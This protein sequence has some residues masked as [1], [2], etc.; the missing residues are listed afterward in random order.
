MSYNKNIVVVKNLTKMF[1]GF[2]ALNNISFELPKNKIVG[3]LGPNGSGK[4]TTI[5][6]LLGLIK[7]TSGEVFIEETNINFRNRTEFLKIINFAS[8]YTEL[9]KKL[10]VK[11]NLTIYARLYNVKNL[12]Q[13]LEEIYEYFDLNNLLNRQIGQL[14]SG[15]K[16][17]VSLA[18][19]LINNP[20]ILFLDEPTASLD[21]V[22]SEYLRNF[23]FDYKK[24]NDISILFSSHNMQEAQKLCDKII[25]LK[26]GKLIEQG[27]V[28]TILLKYNKKNLEE[29]YFDIFK[30]QN[31]Y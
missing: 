9:P 13:R 23:I 4:S 12:K 22:V 3:L 31:E 8:P 27:D 21:P 17:R 14:S 7:E 15:Q 25:I 19:A 24:K 16:T 10:T 11:E 26:A 1:D 5:G 2:F 29:V 28:K 20:K 18:K 6:I 30:K